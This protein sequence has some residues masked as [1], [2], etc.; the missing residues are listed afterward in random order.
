MTRPHSHSLSQLNKVLPVPI[1]L[2]DRTPDSSHF[3]ENSHI[4]DVLVGDY[5][6]ISGDGGRPYI[7]WVIRIIINGSTHN[8]ICIYKRYTDIERF[9][10]M[11]VKQHKDVDIPDLPV[12]DS[13]SLQRMMWSSNWLETRRKGL[14]WF[15]TN[16]LLNPK[17]QHSNVVTEFVLG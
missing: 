1:S 4:T 16:V 11:L 14:Q 6:I 15:M 17:L 10:Q 8:S 13:M 2:E 9:R 5:H 12:K 7:V 3:L